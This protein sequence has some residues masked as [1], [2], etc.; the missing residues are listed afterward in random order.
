MINRHKGTDTYRYHNVNPKGYI[1]SDCM[2]R[3]I[4]LATGLPYEEVIIGLAKTHIETCRCGDHY[5]TYL[6]KLG[7]V[8]NKQPKKPNGKKYTIEE[9]CKKIAKPKEVYVVSCANHLTC[10]VDKEIHDIWNC[11]C[12]SV[13]NY[14]TKGE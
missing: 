1:T 4:T 2:E 10:V 13:G 3:A 7:W 14:W 6:E 9:F 12:K 5:K 11:G 8:K